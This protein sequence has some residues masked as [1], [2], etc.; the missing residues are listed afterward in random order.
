[1]NYPETLFPKCKLKITVIITG[2]FGVI[3]SELE[4]K[5]NKN[6]GRITMNMVG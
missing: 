3:G 4:K 2:G 1:M 6:G 5:L